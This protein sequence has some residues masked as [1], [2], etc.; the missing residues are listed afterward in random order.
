MTED[1]LVSYISAKTKEQWESYEAPYLLTSIATDLR[2]DGKNYKDV[3]G[4]E[5]LKTFAKR[6]EEQGVVKVVEH[7]IQ[8]PKIGVI[9]PEAEFAYTADDAHSDS[10]RRLP[11]ITKSSNEV[12]LIQFFRAIASLPDDLV[13][14]VIIPTK[15]LAALTRR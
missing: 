3:I 7:P 1:E 5:R 8:K 11:R 9:P 10:E 6:L 15:V 13:E 12:V 14:Q 4:E 2:K